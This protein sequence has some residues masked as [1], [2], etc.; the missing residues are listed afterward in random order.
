M[1]PEREL[2]LR[3]LEQGFQQLQKQ[4]A[5]VVPSGALTQFRE[6]IDAGEYGLALEEAQGLFLNES[7]KV[8]PV[9]LQAMGELAKT[10]HVSLR[11]PFASM[12]L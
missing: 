8:T 6:Y 9:I 5:S 2:Y 12:K 7:Q 1:T 4:L 10:M 3:G 11:E